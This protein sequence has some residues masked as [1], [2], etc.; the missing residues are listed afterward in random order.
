MCGWRSVV[1]NHAWTEAEG[2]TNVHTHVLHKTS[3]LLWGVDALPG[4]SKKR[5]EEGGIGK[6]VV[7]VGRKNALENES[8]Q[9]KQNTYTLQKINESGT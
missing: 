6:G 5:D 7:C 8:V 4:I 9:R 3:L 1:V 2:L